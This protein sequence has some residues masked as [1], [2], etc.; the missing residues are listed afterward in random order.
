MKKIWGLLTCLCLAACS[1]IE[2]LETLAPTS[3][4]SRASASAERDIT[5]Y[6]DWEASPY[7]QLLDV[8]G[9]VILPWY[10]GAK[11]AIPAFITNHYKAS[12]GWELVYNFCTPTE[13][14][15]IE[16]DKHFLFFYNI[17]SGRLCVYVYNVNN[18]ISSNH[19]FWRLY[20]NTPSA[21]LN[22]FDDLVLSLDKKTSSY[23][24]LVSTCT[25]SDVKSISLGWNCAEFDLLTYDPTLSS[26]K[27]NMGLDFYDFET[28][29]IVLK[30]NLTLQSEGTILTKTPTTE[31][32]GW[33]NAAQKGITALGDMAAKALED[34]KEGKDKKEEKNSLALKPTKIS[35][36]SVIDLVAKGANKLVA[37]FT[38]RKENVPIATSDVKITTDGISNFVGNF[39]TT[40]H[41]NIPSLMHL[42]IPGTIPTPEDIYLPSYNKPLGVW[43]IKKAPILRISKYS[44]QGFTILNRKQNS[45]GEMMLYGYR[46]IQNYIGV[47][48]EEIEIEI[49]PEVLEKIDHY[50]KEVKVIATGTTTPHPNHQYLYSY[51]AGNE[52]G[53][54]IVESSP[55]TAYG[56]YETVCIYTNT[57]HDEW[58]YQSQ[59]RDIKVTHKELPIYAKIT[60][61][62]C[63]KVTVTLYPKAPYDSTPIVTTRTFKCDKNETPISFD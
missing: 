44:N 25:T 6:F 15:K 12:E 4:A 28:D 60:D 61:E 18:V 40:K 26:Q 14:G 27:L 52:I 55:S 34:K 37:K 45:S 24:K 42:M 39:T 58:I 2:D 19:T 20:F 38:G 5:S 16:K 49:N 50:E 33:A 57:S 54:G 11:G 41:T 32:P 51:Y 9:D 21:L 46:Y 29:S 23:Q 35:W 47:N 3:S 56:K 31:L 13:Q 48:D 43:N 30:G 62:L 22:D 1:D 59:M 17:F 36:A 63:V 8:P 53:A 10:S 7:I